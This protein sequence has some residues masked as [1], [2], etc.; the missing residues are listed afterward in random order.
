MRRWSEGKRSWRVFFELLKGRT[1]A[2]GIPDFTSTFRWHLLAV[3]VRAAFQGSVLVARFPIGKAAI[4]AFS[5]QDGI[6]FD[7]CWN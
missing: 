7:A 2:G 4:S 3:T 1:E 5:G 6:F